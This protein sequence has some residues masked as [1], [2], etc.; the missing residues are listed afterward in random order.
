MHINEVQSILSDAFSSGGN[1]VY[2]LKNYND[3]H[4]CNSDFVLLYNHQEYAYIKFDI[5][6]K[7]TKE[8]MGIHEEKM[9]T[10]YFSWLHHFL[11]HQIAH[12]ENQTVIKIFGWRRV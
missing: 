1:G 6:G 5:T 3:H 9:G 2:E 8:E 4:C 10:A 11:C 12:T 7:M